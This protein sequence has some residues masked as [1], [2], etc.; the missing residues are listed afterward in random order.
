M[1]KKI[2][3][4]LLLAFN[5]T[6][7][8]TNYFVR[9]GASGANN[10]S[11]W[12]NAW[13]G[14]SSIQWAS[15]RAGDTVYVAG[16]RYA[17]TLQI[18][19]SGKADN[20]ITIQRVR[21]TDSAA[22]S[23]AG[24]NAAFDSRVLQD[25]PKS[26]A[27]IYF[28]NSIGSYVTIDGR[29]SSGW[30]IQYLNNSTGIGADGIPVSNITLRY[31]N[32]VGPG[33]ITQTGDTRAINLT[34][35]GGGPLSNVT[36]QYCEASGGDSCVYL[37]AEG[38]VNNA[39]IE[40]SSFHDAGAIN[41]EKYHPNLIYCGKITNSTFRYNKFY[42][43]DVEGLFFGDPGNDNVLIYGNLFYQGS[44]PKNSGR[45][46]EFDYK[47][48]GTNFKIY[49][50]TFASLPLPGIRFSGTNH[51]G[52]DVQNNIFWQTNLSIAPGVKHDHNFFSG[53][54]SEPHGISNGSDPFV[55][56]A[57]YDYHISS[58]IGPA[59][60]RKKGANLGSSY[61]TDIDGGLRG[62]DGRWDI[63]ACEYVNDRNAPSQPTVKV[64]IGQ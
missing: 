6:C 42:N 2:L 63:G 58:K 41:A 38:G 48:S 18:G 54:A 12:N 57:K 47:G 10:G 39:L 30:I 50:N 24:W 13:T 16:G 15:I 1:K 7:F 43:I 56:S 34:P 20:R 31:I 40:H 32:V 5:S 44:I 28:H 23:A 4:L 25:T 49:N 27:G 11:D 3:V 51:A 33:K 26:S 8:A 62:S 19:A 37:A 22:T 60:P 64:G 21:S 61:G 59:S 9:A 29:T 53:P 35:E 36:M 45:G 14:W 46:I 52:C 17:G 55:N